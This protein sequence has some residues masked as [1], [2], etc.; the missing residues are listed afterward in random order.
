MD[1]SKLRLELESPSPI[2]RVV[3]GEIAWEEVN[4]KL[5]EAYDEL[6]QS[7][8]LK[9]FRRGKV[10]RS[11]LAKMFQKRLS[12]ELARGMVQESLVE[13]IGRLSLRPVKNI[14]EWEIENSGIEDGKPVTFTAKLEVLP[15]VEAK[16][17]LEL[18][19][20]RRDAKVT[21]DEVERVLKAQQSQLTQYVPIEGRP[22][23]V[24]DLVRC[25]VMGK[26][27]SEA[28][29][30]DKLTFEI[31]APEVKAA[32]LQSASPDRA[33]LVVLLSAQLAG[34]EAKTGEREVTATFGEDAPE[35][36]RGQ[37]A[38]LLVE[39]TSLQEVK[40]P[41]LDDDLVKDLGETGTLAEY[42]E[43]LKTRLLERDESR[44]KDEER[45]HVVDALIERNPLELSAVLVE[46]Q[47]DAS[48]ERAR[49]AFQM[50]GLDSAA[51][52]YG[53]DRLRDELRP[54][55]ERE[56]KK[57][58]LLDAIAKQEKIEATD[59]DVTTRLQEVAAARG[60]SVER[61]RSDYE[62]RGSIESV[63]A[64]V[65]EEKV[66]DLLLSKARVTTQVTPEAPSAGET[67]TDAP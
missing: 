60:E 46:K 22:V 6:A 37:A 10:P 8:S 14:Q 9:G 67:A 16:D 23:A 51:L 47:L 3:K 55:A 34:S 58:L 50:R 5:D 44:V 29:S 17:Y 56:V 42:R 41:A 39:V 36:W 7:V 48:L 4:V 11:M 62:K 57:T 53:D 12:A 64:L 18:P 30:E 20:T 43:T 49:M 2:Q 61:V 52:G 25:D 35:K 28:V 54:E 15:D 40:Q 27:G 38:N 13:A 24:G 59:D 63:R 32:D 21:D 45:R 31:L 19:V 33:S 66:L 1:E 26:V 65:R